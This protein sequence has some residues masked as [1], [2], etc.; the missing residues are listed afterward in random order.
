MTILDTILRHTRDA[1]AHTMRKVPLEAVEGD[2]DAERTPRSLVEALR[3]DDLAIIAE[4][5]KR[6]P[7]K[8][9]LRDAY[10]PA[11]HA[12]AYEQAGAAALS[13]LTEPHFFDG[14]P[15][16]LRAARAATSLPI[17][18]KD[19]IVD[20]YQIAEARAW[21]ADAVLLIASA[22]DATLLRELQAAADHYGLDALLEV[23]A[24]EDLQHIDWNRARLVGVNNRDLRTFEV[25]LTRAP[26]VFAHLPDGVVCVAESG[27]RDAATLV[28]LRRQ[29]TDAV[30]IGEAFMRADDPG[31]AL[32][33]LREEVAALLRE[34]PDGE[35][36]C[37]LPRTTRDAL[38]GVPRNAP[39]SQHQ[40]PRRVP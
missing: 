16:H 27:L 3:R 4:S 32:R 24:P 29:G 34:T 14:H 26:A 18:R 10:D 5:K 7:S 33:T 12:R 23:H 22:L 31:A 1:L 30:L 21:G 38:Q 37:P 39:T 35:L 36:R 17:L 40:L 11:A 19:F 6:S 15:L 25:D 2:I 13:I 28:Q 20:A 9:Q 8:G